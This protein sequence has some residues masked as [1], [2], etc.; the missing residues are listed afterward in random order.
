[1]LSRFFV[2]GSSL[3]FGNGY[4]IIFG[5]SFEVPHDEDDETMK[6]SIIHLFF[7]DIQL[8]RCSLFFGASLPR[9]EELNS[10]KRRRSTLDNALNAH[11]SSFR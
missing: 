5:M 10:G 3:L 7:E 6:T 2:F 1:M 4:H 8:Y 11:K 9:H